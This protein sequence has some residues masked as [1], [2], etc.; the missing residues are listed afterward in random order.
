MSRQGVQ[1]PRYSVKIRERMTRDEAVAYVLDVL[2][3]RK[4]P[5]KPREY[6]DG[7]SQILSDAMCVSQESIKNYACRGRK[8]LR[9]FENKLYLDCK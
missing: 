9:R 6:A 7:P 1:T 2:M 5:F 3:G 8:T 4:P